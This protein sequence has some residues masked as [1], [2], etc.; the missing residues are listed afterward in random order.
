MHVQICTHA[1]L[2]SNTCRSRTKREYGDPAIFSSIFI[3]SQLPRA[4]QFFTSIIHTW[5]REFKSIP[6]YLWA[7]LSLQNTVGTNVSHRS[8]SPLIYRRQTE[9][10]TANPLV[11]VPQVLR[12]TPGGPPWL[13]STG[14][15]LICLLLVFFFHLIMLPL[16]YPLLPCFSKQPEQ[17]V[18]SEL[19]HLPTEETQ[20]ILRGIVSG[21]AE[22][23]MLS[24]TET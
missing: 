5:G 21:K 6:H 17:K 15:W 2:S 3:Y 13:H 9:A 11:H 24:N 8:N 7:I 19:R 14:V 23:A 4:G 12:P 10:V 1:C 20:F 22:E 16:N 18:S